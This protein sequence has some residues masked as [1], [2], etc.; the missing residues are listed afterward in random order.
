[1]W[2]ITCET[3]PAAAN[4]P[5]PVA[6]AAATFPR[7]HSAC[8]TTA[9][10]CLLAG[11]SAAARNAGTLRAT[12]SPM[13]VVSPQWSVSAAIACRT[14]KRSPLPLRPSAQRPPPSRRSASRGSI[15]GP[16]TRAARGFNAARERHADVSS[17]AEA[18]E[19]P[20]SNSDASLAA[21]GKR[22]REDDL[23]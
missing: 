14:G 23:G 13:H 12:R 22:R 3:P 4:D 2:Y 17:A 8:D 20:F 21:R 6:S 16:A 9:G 10:A 15:L 18:P 7:S 11:S 19:P 1:M 5:T